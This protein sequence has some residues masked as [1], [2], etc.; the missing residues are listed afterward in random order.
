[1]QR[2]LASF[3][4]AVC[5]LLLLAFAWAVV[6]AASPD[7]HESA[8]HDADDAQHECAATMIHHGGIDHTPAPAFTVAFLP[9]VF[10]QV[11]APRLD[12]VPSLFSGSRIFEHG[13]PAL[14]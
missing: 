8:H 13:P 14:A 2:P 9:V 12:W 10:A 1:M 5:A 4:R 11:G 3:R 7:L 6:L